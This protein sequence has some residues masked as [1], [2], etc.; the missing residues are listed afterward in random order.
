[1]MYFKGSVIIIVL[2]ALAIMLLLGGYLISFGLTGFKMYQSHRAATQAYYLGEAGLHQ[3]I[4]KLNNDEITTDGDDPWKI[5]FTGTGPECS[6]CSTWQDSFVRNYTD[7]STTTVSITNSQCGQ[8]QIIATSTLRFTSNQVAQRVMKIEVWRA[9]GG[10]TENSPIFAGA[11]SGNNRVQATLLNVYDGNIFVNNNFEV[12]FWSTVNVFD[13]SDTDFQEGQVL[14][15]GNI[16]ISWTAEVNASSTCSSNMCTEIC[17]KCPPD[18][19][20]MPAI[21]FDSEELTSYK[22]RAQSA[23]N[24]GLCKVTGQDWLGVPVVESDKCIFSENDFKEL[25]QDIGWAGKLILEHSNAGDLGSVYYVEGTVDLRGK[26]ELEVN[27]VLVADRTVDIGEHFC[28]GWRQCGFNQLTINDPGAGWPSGL[29]S[30]SRINFGPFSSSDDVSING[31]IYALEEM[32]LVGSSQEF[33]LKGGMVARKV[34]F[35]SNPAPFNIFL[36]D[37]IIKEGV[38]ASSSPP[39]GDPGDFSPVVNLGHWEEEY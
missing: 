32:R 33:N 18:I 16:I 29:L 4:W 35:D 36:D 21:D 25:L 13:D 19:V 20:E 10:L 5:C 30:K 26:R 39:P 23:E 8:A 28:W 17:E 14:A 6:D 7:D 38:W 37:A 24:A 27:G 3:A 9:F 31:L 11:P 12:K 34:S 1:M 22:S 2:L 15:N